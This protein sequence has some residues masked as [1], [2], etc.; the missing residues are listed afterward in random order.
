MSPI[1]DRRFLIHIHTCTVHVYKLQALVVIVN[2]N[3]LIACCSKPRVGVCGSCYRVARTSV[4]NNLLPFQLT[5][6]VA[7][8][9]YIH[10]RKLLAV[11]IHV[12]SQGLGV[13]CFRKSSKVKNISRFV[14][15]YSVVNDGQVSSDKVL[16]NLL[17]VSA[18]LTTVTRHGQ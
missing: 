17:N 15:V 2:V 10:V 18:S 5:E 1:S 14:F 16:L 7:I 8:V 11:C 3:S 6:L 4:L 12:I 9:L 13:Y